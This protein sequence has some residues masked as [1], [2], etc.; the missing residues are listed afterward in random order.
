MLLIPVIDLLRKESFVV[1]IHDCGK[2][3]VRFCLAVQVYDPEDLYHLGSTLSGLPL[4]AV[5]YTKT[6]I[7]YFPEAVIDAETY[8]YILKE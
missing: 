7:F 5:Y 1:T 4:G 6:G 2:E 3:N 8:T